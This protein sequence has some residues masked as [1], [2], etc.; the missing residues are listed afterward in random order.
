M[1]PARRIAPTSWGDLMMIIG[2]FSCFTMA[3]P[4]RLFLVFVPRD[5]GSPADVALPFGLGWV[6]ADVEHRPAS[7]AGPPPAQAFHQGGLVH[8]ERK[9]GGDL[10]PHLLERLVQCLGLRN[11][12]GEPVENEPLPAIGCLQ[13]VPDDPADH[14]VRPE[15][16]PAHVCLP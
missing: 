9:H 3:V 14:L 8:L 15:P 5:E 10:F 11:R 13:P 7:R 4:D 16:P 6:E 1:D 12:P 2:Y